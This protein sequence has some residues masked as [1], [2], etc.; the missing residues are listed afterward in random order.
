MKWITID[1]K[2]FNSKQEA[3]EWEKSLPIDGI[4]ITKE[5]IIKPP[6][7]KYSK[8]LPVK[9]KSYIN[10]ANKKGIQFSLSVDEFTTLLSKDCVY[11]GKSNASTI[12]R[13]DS[14]EG[15]T[16]ENSAPCCIHCNMMK[17]TLSVEAFI[18]HI[19]S[20]YLHQF[21]NA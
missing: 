18:A 7:K 21:N 3:E 5:V 13:I 11:C 20:V 4:H 15:Y 17:Y 19:K 6:R 10:R 16:Q 12:D 1:N 14:K 2:E 9:Y 8:L